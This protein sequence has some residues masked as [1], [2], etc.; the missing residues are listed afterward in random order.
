MRF[1]EIFN[2]LNESIQGN[3]A[4][5]YHRT[6]VDPEQHP[7][8]K[9]EF[10]A[11]NN[12]RA[13]YGKGLYCT[14][15]L[16]S[17]LNERMRH[18]YGNTILKFKINLNKFFILD[19]D[20]FRKIFPNQSYYDF[21]K[22]YNVS[23]VYNQDPDDEDYDDRVPLYTSDTA[24][25]CAWK[26]QRLGIFDGILFTG[27]HDG[28]VAIV[29]KPET[30][31][32]SS[33]SNDEG[34]T[35]N[36]QSNV[37]RIIAKPPVED[38][39]WNYF[40]KNGKLHPDYV[41]AQNQL[42]DELFYKIF[43][44]KENVYFGG[45]FSEHDR[46]VKFATLNREAVEFKISELFVERKLISPFFIEAMAKFNFLE[47]IYLYDEMLNVYK[48]KNFYSYNT[49]ANLGTVEAEFAKYL[50]SGKTDP[51]RLQQLKKVLGKVKNKMNL[52]SELRE[53]LDQTVVPSSP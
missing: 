39:I 14:Y 23:L 26:I 30:M 28:K 48:N 13:M 22:K 4:W 25:K 51:K 52:R 6:A 2:I 34:K 42:D 38:I 16:Q 40:I 37:S 3:L 19:E 27:R 15:D 12:I 5:L 53:F 7:L 8:F 50:K 46:I 20:V 18:L 21:L 41:N 17:Q 10:I 29:W 31:I 32:L 44:S 9:G 45:D 47:L 43:N 49:G 11:A 36:K 1:R 33:Y 35:W 24:K